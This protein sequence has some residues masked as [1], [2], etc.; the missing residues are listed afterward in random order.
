MAVKI[1][2]LKYLDSNNYD[3]IMIRGNE[4]YQIDVKSQN[5]EFNQLL[6]SHKFQG[7]P[8]STKFSTEIKNQTDEEKIRE[9]VKKYLEYSVISEIANVYHISHYDG[10]FNKISGTRNLYL[11][12]SNPNFKD[13]YQ[14]I[15]RKYI[16]DRLKFCSVNSEIN[17]IVIDC[18]INSSY[19]LKQGNINFV[20]MKDENGI[21]KIEKEFFKELISNKLNQVNK[22]AVLSHNCI[23]INDV[24]TK[25]MIGTI[26]LNCGNLNIEIKGDMEL[27]K[28]LEEIIREYN[29]DLEQ[30]KKMQLKLE[31]F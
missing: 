21:A 11:Q 28:M 20:L 15:L 8:V 13:I 10:W 17:N 18:S 3:S 9:I 16:D 23:I 6:V 29:N 4:N 26:Y 12:I 7:Q 27:F 30:T 22:P 1:N 25:I 24:N 31:G 2:G 5:L 14:M 19:S